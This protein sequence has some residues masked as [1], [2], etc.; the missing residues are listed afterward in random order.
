[1]AAPTA[2]GQP[3]QTKPP[4]VTIP[5]TRNLTSRG[6]MASPPANRSIRNGWFFGRRF[7][8]N[9]TKF[10]PG[11]HGHLIFNPEERRSIL[12]KWQKVINL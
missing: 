3:L 2:S 12:V 7:L 9:L 4:L 11:V 5:A 6:S 8:S 10:F 1:M